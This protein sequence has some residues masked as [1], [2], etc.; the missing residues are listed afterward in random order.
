MPYLDVVSSTASSGQAGLTVANNLRFA[1]ISIAAYEFVASSFLLTLVTFTRPGLSPRSLP[2][3]DYTRLQ[4][5]AGNEVILQ[6]TKI[7]LD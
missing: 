6:V 4:V 3:T 5:S 2:N 7:V 1:S